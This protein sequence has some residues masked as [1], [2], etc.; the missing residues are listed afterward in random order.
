[1]SLT[2]QE[3]ID[4]LVDTSE[5]ETFVIEK[6]IESL[7]KK[8]PSSGG[9]SV[10]MTD[11]MNDMIFWSYPV[12]KICPARR[13]T[14]FYGDSRYPVGLVV[15]GNDEYGKDIICSRLYK[16][17]LNFP[18]F[19]MVLKLSGE[20]ISDEA[21]S[22]KDVKDRID[23]LF[24]FFY[25]DLEI[26]GIEKNSEKIKNALFL[27][28]DKFEDCKYINAAARYIALN[29]R[30]LQTMK[31]PVFVI[32]NAESIDEVPNE[33]IKL[34]RS[35][36][37]D[38]PDY[39]CRYNYLDSYFKRMSL[40]GNITN[41]M[42]VNL[43]ESTADFS[44]KQLSDLV[45]L[46]SLDNIWDDLFVNQAIKAQAMPETHENIKS[47]AY[48]M[49]TE[50]FSKTI[51]VSISGSVQGMGVS[52]SAENSAPYANN[53]N[54]VH[55]QTE[56]YSDDQI[57]ESAENYREYLKTQSIAPMID[58]LLPCSFEEITKEHQENY[59]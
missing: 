51:P 5:R 15:S 53:A 36:T 32:Y 7:I 33:L 55:K 50:F 48:K 41:Q 58:Q 16:N 13:S 35:I 22:I 38:A 1:M 29:V 14:N 4:D 8:T 52:V 37:I 25:P 39:Q 3:W 10:A 20:Y 59:N 6:S 11:P 46:F 49:A 23:G 42:L 54:E 44:Y 40:D 19:N 18:Y 28:L 30:E 2:V 27:V 24:S 34:F 21:E 43:A 17:F 26:N 12:E 47:A 45:Y 9:G 57:L 56:M 31:Y